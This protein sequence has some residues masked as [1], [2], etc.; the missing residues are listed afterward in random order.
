MRIVIVIGRIPVIAAVI[1]GMIVINTMIGITID[2]I[3]MITVIT[4]LK[5][6]MSD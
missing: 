6:G 2:I 4:H 3:S 5:V 1:M